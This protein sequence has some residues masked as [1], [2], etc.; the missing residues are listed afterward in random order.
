MACVSEGLNGAI[1]ELIDVARDTRM[2]SEAAAASLGERV[3][4]SKPG[5]SHLEFAADLPLSV[6]LERT[7]KRVSD[8]YRARLEGGGSGI[9][10]ADRTSSATKARTKAILSQLGMDPTAVAFIFDSTTHGVRQLRGRHGRDPDTGQRLTELRAERVDGQ[11]SVLPPL[12][13]PGG[14][15]LDQLEQ[16]TADGEVGT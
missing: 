13:A 3:T 12:T 2:V 14:A 10:K 15:A 7:I 5:S 8:V 16:R 11:P 4:G 9:A 1:R 6:E